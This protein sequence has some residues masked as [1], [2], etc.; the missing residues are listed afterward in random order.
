MIRAVVLALVAISPACSKPSAEPPPALA[1]AKVGVVLEV[2]GKVTAT[3]DGQTRDLAQGA[4][5][6]TD[7]V[8]A[9]AA[10]GKITIELLHNHARWSL[11]GGRQGAVRTSAAWDLPVVTQVA[12]AV[13]GDSSAAGR[14]AERSAVDTAASATDKNEPEKAKDVGKRDEPTIAT[15]T[16]TKTTKTP[17]PPKDPPR[18]DLSDSMGGMTGT[19]KGG[20]GNGTGGIGIGSIGTIGHGAGGGDGYGAGH[21]RLGGGPAT[22]P[23]TIT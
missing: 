15:T 11:G 23:P 7:D 6:V 2:T 14:P 5:V 21:G 8:I 20:G 18:N 16:T 22:K 19:G 4:E 17:I 1:R 3:H 10:D 12:A 9:T 13:G